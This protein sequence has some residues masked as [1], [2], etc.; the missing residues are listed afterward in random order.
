MGNVYVGFYFNL[1]GKIY[2]V[3]EDSNCYV[4]DLGNVV[5]GGDGKVL[6]WNGFYLC[7]VDI[8]VNKFYCIYVLE[9]LCRDFLGFWY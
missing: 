7:V 9:I 4:G 5:V 6:N 2:G 8:F 3:L 1:E